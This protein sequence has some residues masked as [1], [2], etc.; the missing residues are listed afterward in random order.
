MAPHEWP[1]EKFDCYV[2]FLASKY[3]FLD[4]Y[5]ISLVL[6]DLQ[7]EITFKVSRW[8]LRVFRKHRVKQFDTSGGDCLNTWRH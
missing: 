5:E 6:L 7:L 4:S 2:V 8:A 3:H 1:G